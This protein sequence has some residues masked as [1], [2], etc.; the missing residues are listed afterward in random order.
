[1]ILHLGQRLFTDAETL[2][3]NSPHTSFNR[4]LLQLRQNFRLT[5]DNSNGVLKVGR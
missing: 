1:M 2:I 4:G 5:I 3:F